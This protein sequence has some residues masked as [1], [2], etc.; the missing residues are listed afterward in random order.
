MSEAEALASLDDVLSGDEP[1]VEV[2]TGEPEAQ[3]EEAAPEAAPEVEPEVEAKAESEQDST[4]ESE[5]EQE[6]TK[7]MALDERRK[8]QE[9]ERKL[10]EIQAQKEAEAKVETPDV[11]EN[12]DAFVEHMRNEM[13]AEAAKIRIETSQEIMRS[14]HSDYDAKE[15]AFINMA[16][17]NPLLVQEMNQSSNPAKFAYDTVVKAEKLAML[18]NVDELE[19]RIRSELEEK[20]RAEIQGESQQKAENLEKKQK[21]IPPSLTNTSGKSGFDSDVD[22]TLDDILG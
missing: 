10:E 8:R 18:N 6:W 17:E 4:P 20:I 13:K 21:S 22:E 2:P 16:K 9:I 15:E 7:T 3:T 12:Q 5:I 14:L 19:A 11:F 1:A